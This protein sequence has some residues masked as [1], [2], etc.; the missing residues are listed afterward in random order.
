MGRGRVRQSRIKSM[1]RH[2]PLWH[3][4]APFSILVFALCL[5][6]GAAAQPYG[7][8]LEGNYFF[9]EPSGQIQLVGSP[10]PGPVGG[11][12]IFDIQQDLGFTRKGTIPF[13]VR[14]I[15]KGVRLEGEYLQWNQTAGSV[16]TR[17]F[18]FQGV[19]YLANEAI[20]SELRFRDISGSLRYEF[21]LGGYATLGA[22]LDIDALKAEGT[23]SA[24]TRNVSASDSRNFIVPTGTVGLN[25]H[26]GAR[27]VFLDIK[28]SY[29]TYQGSKAQKGRVELGW[30]ITENAG[31]KAGWRTLDVTYVKEHE[32]VVEDR[33]HVKLD[34]FYGGVFLVF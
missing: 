1:K 26:D 23:I 18:V 21:Q 7:V 32:P 3:R 30:A 17:A 25:F 10:L 11:P 24:V 29:I 34:G 5:S 9:S 16:L 28:A 31:L 33:I 6:R 12:S 15:R 19:T 13:G 22:G 14:L 27:H 8:M 2:S 4:L 20:S